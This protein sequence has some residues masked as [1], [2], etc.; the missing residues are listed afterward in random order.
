MKIEGKS[1]R[2]DTQAMEIYVTENQEGSL[3]ESLADI[4]VKVSIT[5]GERHG[6]IYGFSRIAT[7]T[8]LLASACLVA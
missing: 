8:K 1:T 4:S 3:K 5:F 2:E 6:Q 7:L